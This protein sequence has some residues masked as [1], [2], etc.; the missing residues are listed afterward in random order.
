MVAVKGVARLAAPRAGS[1]RP[2]RNL[3]SSHG[4]SVMSLTFKHCAAEKIGM[5]MVRLDPTHL[6]LEARRMRRRDALSYPCQSWVIALEHETYRLLACHEL[7]TLHGRRTA[8]RVGMWHWRRERFSAHCPEPP[9]PSPDSQKRDDGSDA[10]KPKPDIATLVGAFLGLVTGFISGTILGV[11]LLFLSAA[12][13]YRLS[14]TMEKSVTGH[15]TIAGAILF[16]LVLGAAFS[17]IRVIL[18]KLLPVF[19]LMA[20][21]LLLSVS[22]IIFG[23]WQVYFSVI[24]LIRTIVAPFIVAIAGR[25]ALYAIT[26]ASIMVFS[27]IIYRLRCTSR[28]FYGG[29]EIAFGVASIIY[30]SMEYMRTLPDT[31]LHGNVE[32]VVTSSSNIPLIA[33]VYIIIRGL[34]NVEDGIKN[35]VQNLDALP[36]FWTK[37]FYPN[38]WPKVSNKL[39]K[40]ERLFDEL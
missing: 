2:A 20:I 6:A 24:P 5:R 34:A 10:D 19:L 31:M 33:G 3:I 7:D 22:V 25:A 28:L 9:P 21:D 23:V 15:G 8:Q 40:F 1:C 18:K 11:G 36:I 13:I 26:S 37:L 12:G 38:P 27:C 35:K 30:S 32:Q 4:G 14:W 39:G 17:L 29:L 16:S